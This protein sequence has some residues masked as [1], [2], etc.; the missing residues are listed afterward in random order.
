M[1][2]MSPSTVSWISGLHRSTALGVK[3]RLT[4][5]RRRVWVSPSLLTRRPRN[6]STAGPASK[7]VAAV[8]YPAAPRLR[9][10][11]RMASITRS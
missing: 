4:S 3:E 10:S 2:S 9:R 5:L 6:S 1:A 11:S 7:S 8:S